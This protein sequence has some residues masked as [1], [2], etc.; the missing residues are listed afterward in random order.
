MT[1]RARWP[2]LAALI[3]TAIVAVLASRLARREPG[4]VPGEPAVEAPADSAVSG[5]RTVQLWFAAR[6]GDGLEPESREVI[7][8]TELRDRI[9]ALVSELDHGPEAGGVAVLP[10]GTAVLHVFLD[11]RGWLTLD[12]SA[13]FRRGFRGGSTAEHLAIGS[14]LRTI[15]DNVP[16]ARRVRLVCD[17]GPIAT[18]G[19]H[20][21]LDR[22]LDVS[23]WR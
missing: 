18:L 21:P 16:E 19:G 6:D 20:V 10:P 2:W 14:L 12:L 22:P 23:D 15:G 17:G 3:V 7:E 1:R 11:D 8:Q 9:A 5:F 4:A 13:E